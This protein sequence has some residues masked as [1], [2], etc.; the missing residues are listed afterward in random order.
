MWIVRLSVWALVCSSWSAAWCPW[1]LRQQQLKEY[2]KDSDF[3]E[4]VS[5]RQL[6]RDL[7]VKLV[8]CDMIPFIVRLFQ[9]QI[10]PH[11]S[12]C[13]TDPQLLPLFGQPSHHAVKVVLEEWQQNPTHRKVYDISAR[14]VTILTKRWIDII[15][16]TAAASISSTCVQP[17]S[18]C[19]TGPGSI[20]FADEYIGISFVSFAASIY[21]LCRY[22]GRGL[23]FGMRSFKVNAAFG[24]LMIKSC[25]V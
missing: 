9:Q 16:M 8:V 18:S 13:V 10:F 7:P 24:Q 11:E 6:A 14:A 21:Q 1:C 5:L 20:L 12:L 2:Q 22:L 23:F 15:G 3:L 25:Q 17:S 4:P 19:G